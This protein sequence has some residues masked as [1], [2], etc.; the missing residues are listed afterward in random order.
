MRYGWLKLVVPENGTAATP[1]DPADLSTV[2][3]RPDS[4]IQRLRLIES[5]DGA[6]PEDAA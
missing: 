5:D 1:E 3:E 6:P 2:T 4:G